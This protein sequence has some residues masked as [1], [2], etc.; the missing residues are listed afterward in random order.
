[1]IDDSP[2]GKFFRI[3]WFFG[4]VVFC[5]LAFQLSAMFMHSRFAWLESSPL[6]SNTLFL[7][8]LLNFLA[9]LTISRPSRKTYHCDRGENE[10]RDPFVGLDRYEFC[11]HGYGIDQVKATNYKF[12]ALS[13][14]VPGMILFLSSIMV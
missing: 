9:A 3:A 10:Y 4:G 14:A 12:Q 8:S 2:K 6:L 7:T 1:M 13:F 11:D 5:I